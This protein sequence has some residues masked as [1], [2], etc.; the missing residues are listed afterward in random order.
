MTINTIFLIKLGMKIKK[1]NKNEERFR[2]FKAAAAIIRDDI[3]SVVVDNDYYPP[4]S[5]MFEN[6]DQDIP[7][8]LTHFVEKV[9]LKE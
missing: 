5:Q 3:R 9:S 4:P 6:V 7:E 8:S 1:Q 2:I